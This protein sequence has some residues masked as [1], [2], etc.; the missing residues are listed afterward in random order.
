MIRMQ[1]SLYTKITWEA[2]KASHILLKLRPEFLKYL[3]LL[4]IYLKDI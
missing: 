2:L 3:K 1:P 4:L